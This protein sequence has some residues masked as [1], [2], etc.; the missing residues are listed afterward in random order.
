MQDF[1]NKVAVITGAGS[2]IGK[3]IALECARRKMRVVLADINLENLMQC[4]NEFKKLNTTP[5]ALVI[6]VSKEAD[7]KR[8]AKATLDA[9]GA[10]H[11]LFNNAG[12]PGPIGPIWEIDLAEFEHTMTCNLMGV[13]YGLREFIPLM[14]KQ[15]DECHIVNTASGAGLH[16]GPNMSAYVASKHAIVALSEVLHFDLWQRDE[17]IHVSLLCPGLVATS[18]AD[19]LKAKE[20]DSKEVKELVNFFKTAMKAEGM[21]PS[22]IADLVFRAIERKQFYILSHIAQHKELIKNRME[23][24]LKE[25]NPG[26]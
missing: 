10:V 21:S 18:F 15:K 14:L 9:Y 6:D 11:I 24:I 23:N 4:E 22:V 5:I 25:K 8:L 26:T 20:T 13:V 7:I 12:I 16:T 19:S 1:K 2:G 17:N 3:A